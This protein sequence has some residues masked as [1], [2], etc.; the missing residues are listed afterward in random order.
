MDTFLSFQTMDQLAQAGIFPIIKWIIVF[1]FGL[2]LI[3]SIV[4]LTQINR[5]FGVLSTGAKKYIYTLSASH[6][7][8]TA[9]ALF[10]AIIRLK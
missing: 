3:F 4:V 6:L 7:I 9:V 5:M 8:F 2:G 1:T 10:W